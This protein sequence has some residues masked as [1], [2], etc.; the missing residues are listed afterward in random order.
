MV[1]MLQQSHSQADARATVMSQL[2][3]LV[4]NEAPDFVAEAVFDQEFQT[5]S[6][7]QYRVGGTHC[8]QAR[9]PLQDAS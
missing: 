1:T 5:I 9:G 8:Q 4:G 2:Q 3:P 6:L 7:S